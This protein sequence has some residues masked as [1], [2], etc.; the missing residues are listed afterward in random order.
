MDDHNTKGATTAWVK[1]LEVRNFR[2]FN[3]YVLNLSYP[4]T[5]I[6]GCNGM[7]KTSL[8]E[9]LYYGCYLRSFR[10]V[11]TKEMVALG[12]TSFFIKITLAFKSSFGITE[13]HLHI[14]FSDGAR[15]VKL[16]DRV[17]SSYRELMGILRIISITESDLLLIQGPPAERRSFIDYALLLEDV[18]YAHHI[19]LL[20]Q[21]VMNRNALLQKDMHRYEDYIVFTQQL[22]E[23]TL[24]IQKIRSLYIEALQH[25]TNNL[26]A[27]YL[28]SDYSLILSYAIKK[29]MGNCS[30]EF[31]KKNPSLHEQEIR[32]K[33]SLF[34]A[35]LDDIL[36]IYNNKGSRSFASRGQQKLILILLK[37]AQLTLLQRE[38]PGAALLFL[39]DDYMTD[40]DSIRAN[41]ILRALQGLPVQ[42]V[43]TS[44]IGPN[45][46]YEKIILLKR[47]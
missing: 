21:I 31:L 30:S 15:H 27:H 17:I 19:V 25:E 46:F 45:P 43:L 36:F 1:Q 18:Q 28:G 33:R 9:A 10:T 41:A 35:H 34:G 6:E 4:H 22:W 20:K 11:S 47:L 7:G 2:C 37:M 24:V 23:Q 40:F 29:E 13:S 12:A 16:D 5:L 14:G 32:M 26:I 42:L 3:H 44:P 38:S 39:I 8:L